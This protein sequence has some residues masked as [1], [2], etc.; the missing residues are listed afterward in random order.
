M[1]KILEREF[2]LSIVAIIA[3]IWTAAQGII[4]AE[5]MVKIMAWVAMVYAIARS[6]VKFTKT[7]KDDEILAKIEDIFKKNK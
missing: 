2:I 4:P 5:L 7:T 3:S 6:I 1:K